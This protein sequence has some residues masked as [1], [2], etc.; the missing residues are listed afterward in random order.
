VFIL[1]CVVINLYF[2]LFSPYGLNHLKGSCHNLLPDLIVIHDFSCR[3]FLWFLQLQ[4]CYQ[5][6]F[7]ADSRMFLPQ[8]MWC[9]VYVWKTS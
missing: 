3:M 2:L 6:M 4:C 1:N 7:T 5:G 8:D 9:Y